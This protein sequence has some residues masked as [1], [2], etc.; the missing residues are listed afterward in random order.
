MLLQKHH[1]GLKLRAVMRKLLQKFLH[2]LP[3]QQVMTVIQIHGA[4]IAVVAVEDEDAVAHK[5]KA[6]M[7]PI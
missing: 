3:V 4:V 2:L 5:V 1:V 7:E 6:Q